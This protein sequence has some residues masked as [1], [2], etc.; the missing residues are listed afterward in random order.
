MGFKEPKN[1]IEFVEFLDRETDNWDLLCDCPT[2]DGIDPIH[3]KKCRTIYIRK[4][5]DNLK[6]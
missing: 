3:D 6:Q 4:L 5:F 1:I 2:A